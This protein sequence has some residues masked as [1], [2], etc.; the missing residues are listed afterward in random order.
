MFRNRNHNTM[1]KEVAMKQLAAAG[2][3]LVFLQAPVQAQTAGAD[4]TWVAAAGNDANPCSS[5][6]P[7]R[8]FAG[9]I[10]IRCPAAPSAS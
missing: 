1:M 4:R 6:M 5:T 8:T 7:C 10:A 3:M 9:A 2:L